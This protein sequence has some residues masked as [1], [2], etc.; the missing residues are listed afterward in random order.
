MGISPIVDLSP[1]PSLTP[2]INPTATLYA[3]VL[4]ESIPL[5]QK[6]SMVCTAVFSVLAQIPQ[7]RFIANLL[8]KVSTIVFSLFNCAQ[9]DS[10][11]RFMQVLQAV[12]ALALAVFGCVAIVMASPLLFAISSLLESAMQI[13]LAIGKI[14]EGDWQEALYHFALSGTCVLS[15]VSLLTGNIPVALSSTALGLGLSI[16]TTTRRFMEGRYLE[17]A[18]GLVA[19]GAQV[20]SLTQQSIAYAQ[21]QKKQTVQAI[22]PLNQEYVKTCT[23]SRVA[24]FNDGGYNDELFVVLGDREL[25]LTIRTYTGVAYTVGDQ[26]N[27]MFHGDQDFPYITVDGH[28]FMNQGS[29]HY[30]LI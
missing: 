25:I 15:A 21:Y 6:V 19:A 4:T 10:Q 20:A 28:R 16:Y 9:L 14:I 13:Y 27:V 3:D 22:A 23:V 8:Q 1:Y 30:I 17:G 5:L 12:A 2:E 7:I 29:N 26:V 18:C 24:F 11:S